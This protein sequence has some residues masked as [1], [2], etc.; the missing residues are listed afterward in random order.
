MNPVIENIKA[1]HSVRS[2]KDEPI[3]REL[4]DIVMEA[5][6]YAPSG[7]NNQTSKFY[8]I[9]NKKFLA[10]MTAVAESEFAKMEVYDGMYKSLR[11]AVVR[12]K[13]GSYN[14]TYSAPVNIIVTNRKGYG[15]AMADSTM[16]LMN[17][18]LAAQSLGLGTVYTNATHWLDESGPF[19]ELLATIGVT[20]EETVCCGMSIGWP[21]NPGHEVEHFGNEVI[22]IE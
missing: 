3:P 14:F 17:M 16:A 9:S 18:M 7:G 22:Y 2:Y 10:D 5:G 20:D 21:E 8:V 11:S 15:N 19:R 13:N 1:R 12:S 4:L 6:R